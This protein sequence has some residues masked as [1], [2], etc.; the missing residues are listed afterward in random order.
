MDPLRFYCE[1]CRQRV[2]G[3]RELAPPSR[4][5]LCAKCKGALLDLA[6]EQAWE[7]LRERDR[8]THEH[9]QR[10][11]IGFYAITASVPGCFYVFFLTDHLSLQSIVDAWRYIVVFAIVVGGLGSYIANKRWP[12]DPIL[13]Q[14]TEEERAALLELGQPKNDAPS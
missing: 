3:P 5:L 1:T 7:Y 8:T 10:W 14:T 2:A 12:N 9:R 13:A 4:G 11:V 6:T